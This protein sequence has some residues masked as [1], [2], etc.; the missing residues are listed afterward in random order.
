MK[1]AKSLLIGTFATTGILIA[2]LLPF[3]PT[4]HALEP[5]VPACAK[6]NTTPPLSCIMETFVNIANL[7]FGISGGAALLMFVIGGFMVLTSAGNDA[8]VTKGKEY[9]KNAVIGLFII[10]TAAY[11]IQYGVNRITKGKASGT[12]PIFSCTEYAKKAGKSYKCAKPGAA[13]CMPGFDCDANG[14]LCCPTP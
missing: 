11:V 8:K 7:I 4:A 10:F 6:T 5:L 1:F 13:G 14:M 2:G 12:G 9:L 3:V